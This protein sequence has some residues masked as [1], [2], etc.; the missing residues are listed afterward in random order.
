VKSM[1]PAD[2]PY[3]VAVT[4]NAMPGDR[5]ICL[6]AGM[7]DYISKP[8]REQDL[9]RVLAHLGA[10]AKASADRSD[11]QILKSAS[12]IWDVTSAIENVGGDK[13]IIIEIIGAF[14]STAPE[15]LAKIGASLEAD[16]IE[17]LQKTAHLFKGAVLTLGESQVA[18]LA[19]ELNAL[20]V[21]GDSSTCRE[22]CHVKWLEMIAAYEH[23]KSEL[24]A[25]ARSA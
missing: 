12:Q 19:R 21:K 7:D 2:R 17:V 14:L 3:I 6:E 13:T 1:A 4:A 5:E 20:A 18:N 10:L 22:Q 9:R 15:I 8:I 25:F 16:E 24:E 11:R 23:F